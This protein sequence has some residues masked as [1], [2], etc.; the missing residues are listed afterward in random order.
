[1]TEPFK[2]GGDNR[3]FAV[4][5]HRGDRDRQSDPPRTDP[6]GCLILSGQA[7]RQT[8][9]AGVVRHDRIRIFEEEIPDRFVK[10]RETITGTA[11][12]PETELQE[13]RVVSVITNLVITS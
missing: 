6:P 2:K 7:D 11:V 8:L 10:I 13:T 5:V 1:M 4:L 3:Q 12:Q 9:R